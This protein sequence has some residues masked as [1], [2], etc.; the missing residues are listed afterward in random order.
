[1]SKKIFS[2][3]EIQL[4][5]I[6]PYVKSISPKGIT[7]SEEFKELFIAQYEKGK[8]PSD[9]FREYGLDPEVV[10]E[11]RINSASK[12]WREAYRKNGAMGLR[13]T[14]P[15]NSGR[16]SDRELSIEEKYKK[17]QAEL[18]LVKAENE[19]LKKIRLEE[20]RMKKK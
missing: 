19:L 6:N 13:D 10:G 16:P 11:R 14:R 5:S 8:F 4:L 9:I 2:S 18:N 20:R 15:G 12:R 3:K 1:M 7:Y 17:L